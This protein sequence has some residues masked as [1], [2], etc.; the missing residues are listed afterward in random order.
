MKRW[1]KT[2]EDS[3]W[4]ACWFGPQMR[5]PCALEPIH[6]A[7]RQGVV[8]TD[9]RQSGPVLEREG[10]QAWEVLGSELDALDRGGIRRQA[11]V[12]HACITRGAPDFG[13]VR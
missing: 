6:D 9:D 1:E 11:F 10:E 3:N 5:S 2:F 8:R 13:G 4:A 12:G 7:Q